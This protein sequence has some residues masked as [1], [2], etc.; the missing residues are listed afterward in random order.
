MSVTDNLNLVNLD[1]SQPIW[2]HFFTVAPLI[3]VGTKE[4]GGNYDLAPKHMAMPLG[5]DNYFTFVCTPR[6]RTYQNIQRE[7]NFTISF[8]NPDQVVLASLTATPRCDGQ[9]KPIL[10]VLPTI[11]ASLIDGVFLKDSYLFLECELERIIDGFGENSLIIGKIIAAAVDQQSFR[12]S[13]GDQ[14]DLILER[15]LLAYLSPNR[16]TQ[17]ERSF[18]FPFPTGFEK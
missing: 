6:H 14:Q 18:S 3:V 4:I 9:E 7:G 11:K 5:W 15:P 16:Y 12:A 10:A 13:G 2:P 8:P 1:P 17:I